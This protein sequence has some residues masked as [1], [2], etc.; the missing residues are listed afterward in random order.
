MT[1]PAR[2]PGRYDEPRAL[3]PSL[4]VTGAVVLGALLVGLAYLAYD[5]FSGGRVRFA[6][7]GYTVGGDSSVQVRFEVRKDLRESVRCRLEARDR[8]GVVVGSDQVLVGPSDRE[9]V[10]TQRTLVTSRRAA[11]AQV[12]GCVVAQPTPEPSGP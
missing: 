4:R 9:A 10:V 12:S 5:R 6:T 1:V 3:S 8:D 2:P 7:L 11:T